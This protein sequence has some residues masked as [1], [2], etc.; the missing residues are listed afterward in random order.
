MSPERE[1]PPGATGGR[2]DQSLARSTDKAHGS[3]GEAGIT[4]YLLTHRGL[5][6]DANER[7]RDRKVRE[8]MLGLPAVPARRW[9]A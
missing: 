5:P 1:R 8:F 9:A 7:Q 6:G 2:N 4:A 3:S